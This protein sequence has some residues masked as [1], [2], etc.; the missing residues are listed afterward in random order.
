MNGDGSVSFKLPE[1]PGT[2]DISRE[3][4]NY[5]INQVDSRI[6]EALADTEIQEEFGFTTEQLTQLQKSSELKFLAGFSP[7]ADLAGVID[8]LTGNLFKYAEDDFATIADTI[9][10]CNIV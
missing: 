3:T 1:I 10:A 2:I 7:K 9:K 5:V 8:I 4:V 6:K